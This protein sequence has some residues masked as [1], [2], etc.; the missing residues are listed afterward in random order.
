MNPEHVSNIITIHVG[1]KS[2]MSLELGLSGLQLEA[3]ATGLP[4]T[5]NEYRADAIYFL[6]LLLLFKII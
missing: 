5:K 1:F 3:V 6:L 2:A 4:R